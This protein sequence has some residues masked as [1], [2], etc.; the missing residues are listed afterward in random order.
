MEFWDKKVFF[1]IFIVKFD[2]KKEDIELKEHI[3]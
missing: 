2:K 1:D 3:N